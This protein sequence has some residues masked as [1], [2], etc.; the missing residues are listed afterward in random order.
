MR[1]VRFGIFLDALKTD[2]EILAAGES[3]PAATRAGCGDWVT[4]HLAAPVI[5]CRTCISIN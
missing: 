5:L 4:L 3:G 2:R 1:S